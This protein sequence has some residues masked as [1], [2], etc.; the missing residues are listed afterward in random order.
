ML[1]KEN[2]LKLSDMILEYDRCKKQLHHTEFE[3]NQEHL[4][5]GVFTD[6]STRLTEQW[7][8][9]MQ[10]MYRC[11]EDI[12]EFVKENLADIVSQPLK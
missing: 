12:S 5:N 1:S 7:A 3:I 6:E 11:T 2:A 4:T 9:D 8:A 10:K